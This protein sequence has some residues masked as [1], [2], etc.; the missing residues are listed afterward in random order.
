MS[1]SVFLV[2]VY[3]LANCVDQFGI[4]AVENVVMYRML[5]Y[6]HLFTMDNWSGIS[7]IHTCA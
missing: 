2:L 5:S 4:H 7:V 3:C 6:R 1:V